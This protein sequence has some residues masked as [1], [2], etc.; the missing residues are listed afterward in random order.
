[1]GWKNQ[2]EKGESPALHFFFFFA[3][4]VPLQSKAKKK[5]PLFSLTVQ[6]QSQQQVQRPSGSLYFFS[7]SNPNWRCLP[8]GE[9]ATE[10]SLAEDGVA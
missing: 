7:S 3:L 5:A 8:V 9:G 6:L 2:G 10:C 4:S 1:V